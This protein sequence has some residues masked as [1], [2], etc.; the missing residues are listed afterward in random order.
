[1]VMYKQMY[2]RLKDVIFTNVSRECLTKV[3]FINY[4]VK[5]LSYSIP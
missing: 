2:V 1:M 4:H 3:T 5:L